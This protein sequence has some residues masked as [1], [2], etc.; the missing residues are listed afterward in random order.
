MNQCLAEIL[1]YMDA[2]EEML[3]K[4]EQRHT[5]RRRK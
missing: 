2:R 5:T 3:R 4:N 1:D